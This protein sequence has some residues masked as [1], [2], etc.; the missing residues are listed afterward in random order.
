MSGTLNN[1]SLKTG[2]SFDLGKMNL[3]QLWVAYLTYPTILLY[4]ALI[5]V[6][7][8]IAARYFAGWGPTLVAVVA[9]MA[10][11][12]LAWYLLHRYVLHG[13]LLYKNRWTASLWK[14]IHFDHHQDPHLLDVLFG[15]P[16]TTLP[17]II[18]ITGPIGYLI[19]GV[20][21]AATA[22]GTGI[23]ITCIYEFFHCIQHLNYKPRAGWIQRMKARHVLHHFHDEDGNFGITSFVIDRMFGSYYVDAKA[24]P[25]SPTVFN[26]GYDLQQAALYPWVMRCTGAPPRDRPD[27]ARPEG[28]RA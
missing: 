4:F 23:T 27:G 28:K 25:R 9:V 15:A 3:Q 11:Y 8:G 13:H 19:G 26:L 14:R 2:R 24:R 21:A 18:A 17:T 22:I 1:A 10:V 7:F 16:V 6:S 12:P 5:I 20:G